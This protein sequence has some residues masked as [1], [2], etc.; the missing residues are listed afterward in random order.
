MWHPEKRELWVEHQGKI[1]N[2]F[3]YDN[4]KFD[5]HGDLDLSFLDLKTNEMPDLSKMT[6]HGDL[7]VAHNELSGF[8]KLPRII[9]GS[10]Y[11]SFNRISSFDDFPDLVAREC[12]MLGNPYKGTKRIEDGSLGCPDVVTQD[13]YIAWREEQTKQL[14]SVCGDIDKMMAIQEKIGKYIENETGIR[15]KVTLVEP[16]TLPRFEGKAKRVIDERDL[17]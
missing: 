5:W 16:K 7:N 3:D 9:Y 2:L 15:V 11:V 10:L 12:V 4:K 14:M 8:Q 6:V 17:H 13:Y 1:L